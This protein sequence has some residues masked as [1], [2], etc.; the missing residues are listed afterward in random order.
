[1]SALKGMEGHA[2]K[3]FGCAPEAGSISAEFPSCLGSAYIIGPKIG[4][5]MM[6]AAVLSYLLLIPLIKFFGEAD[7][8]AGCAGV[9]ADQR[10]GPDDVRG[11]IFL[12]RRRSVAAGGIISL[13]RSL[14]IIVGGMRAGL[15]DFGAA[16]GARHGS[17]DGTG[18]F[19]EI[20]GRRLPGID[21]G[22]SWR[23]ERCT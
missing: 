12:H 10:H 22:R 17:A 9:G 13:I 19:D 21:R 4:S 23:R 14:P 1:M 15:A 16:M 6:E 8:H 20:C 2:E 7:Q 18:P 3:I 5:I 11:R